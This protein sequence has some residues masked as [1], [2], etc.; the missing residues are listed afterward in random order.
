MNKTPLT[1]ASLVNCI[2]LFGWKALKHTTI[3]NALTITRLSDQKTDF[4]PGYDELPNG[5]IY[6]VI[7]SKTATFFTR[8][9][10]NKIVLGTITWKDYKIKPIYA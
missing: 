1:V 8:Q 2:S 4:V 7:L 3:N 6:E 10:I 5:D 9:E